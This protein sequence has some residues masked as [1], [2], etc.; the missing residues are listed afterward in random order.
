MLAGLLFTLDKPHPLKDYIAVASAFAVFCLLSGVVYLVNDC[1]DAN[2]DRKHP[3]K[4]NRPIASGRLPTQTAWT[5]VMF[6]L[7]IGLGISFCVNRTL[8]IL[9]VTYVALMFFYSLYLKNIVLVDVMVIGVGFVLR[10]VAGTEAL[11]VS[12]SPWLLMCTMLLALF[13]A[14]AKRRGELVLFEDKAVNTRMSLEHYSVPFLDQLINVTASAT[15]IAYALYTFGSETAKTHRYMIVTLP[16]VLYGIFRYML[17]VHRG[18]GTDNPEMLLVTDRPL[19]FDIALW[20]AAC[21]IV[22]ATK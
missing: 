12:I 3:A 15:I 9:S 20:A 8:G 10:A 18:S 14:V 6:L 16:F 17:L 1:L 5:A 21:A 2:L 22:I 19:L 7:V 13:L 11:G 4:R